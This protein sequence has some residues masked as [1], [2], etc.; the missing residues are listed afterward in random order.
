MP[1]MIKIDAVTLRPVTMKM[2]RLINN[3]YIYDDRKPEMFF[4]LFS[5]QFL[6][7]MKDHTIRRPYME[8]YTIG[9]RRKQLGEHFSTGNVPPNT[10][11]LM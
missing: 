9:M 10:C 7:P 11:L 8:P 4:V 3:C 6:M 5:H 2:K 1:P